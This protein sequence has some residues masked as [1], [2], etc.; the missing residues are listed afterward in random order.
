MSCPLQWHKN[1]KIF[2]CLSWLWYFEWDYVCLFWW[3]VS[4]VE[5]VL[6]VLCFFVVFFMFNDIWMCMYRRCPLSCWS[7]ATWRGTR[8]RV[9]TS[10]SYLYFLKDLFFKF[11]KMFGLWLFLI[12]KLPS[13]KLLRKRILLHII[14]LLNAN[15]ARYKIRTSPLV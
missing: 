9:I 2:F 5:D 8:T 6:C 14:S 10:R 15:M 4:L 7:P 13:H 1:V 11:G 3:K 12:L